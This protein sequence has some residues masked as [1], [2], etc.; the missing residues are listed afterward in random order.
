MFLSRFRAQAPSISFSAPL[1]VGDLSLLFQS[2]SE[3]VVE[4]LFG[5]FLMPKLTISGN[6]TNANDNILSHNDGRIP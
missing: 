2:L 1:S 6:V 4:D 5:F 3:Q